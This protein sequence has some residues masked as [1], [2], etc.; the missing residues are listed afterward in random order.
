MI[1]AYLN[2]KIEI[3]RDGSKILDT[4]ANVQEGQIY[5]GN[6]DIRE[7]DIIRITAARIEYQVTSVYTQLEGNRILYKEVKYNKVG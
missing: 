4:K 3:V 7:L 5:L 1:N 2:T 6:V